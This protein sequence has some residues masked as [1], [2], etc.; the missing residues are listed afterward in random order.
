MPL[1]LETND[2]TGD[3]LI[4]S[5]SLPVGCSDR[6]MNMLKQLRRRDSCVWVRMDVNT[7][8]WW[9]EAGWW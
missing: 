1:L 5:H 4:L 6:F 2:S 3:L 8:E 7:A 9:S